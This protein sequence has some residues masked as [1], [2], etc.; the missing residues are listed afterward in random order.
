MTDNSIA[1]WAWVSTNTPGE[2]AT[3]TTEKEVLSVFKKFPMASIKGDGSEMECLEE[4]RREIEITMAGL[5]INLNQITWK[6]KRPRIIIQ[7]G[8]ELPE[9]DIKR[10]G[11]GLHMSMRSMVEGYRSETPLFRLLKIKE[12]LSS[13]GE[14]PKGYHPFIH[15]VPNSGGTWDGFVAN[16]NK[17]N[18]PISRS[19]KGD[20][21][22]PGGYILAAL[23]SWDTKPPHDRGWH[24]S[25][26]RPPWTPPLN[27]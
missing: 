26:A 21:R 20:Y 4:S 9:L 6:E 23:V 22:T 12:Q 1:I 10:L 5:D 13:S 27:P 24:F 19:W 11:L 17:L 25:T 14:C 3:T 18:P 8:N 15:W 2:L 16:A 7:H